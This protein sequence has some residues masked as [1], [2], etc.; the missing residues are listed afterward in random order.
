[1][2]KQAAKYNKAI[3]TGDLNF[4]IYDGQYGKFIK[5]SRYLDPLG[6]VYAPTVSPRNTNR[7]HSLI[8]PKHSIRVDYTLISKNLGNQLKKQKIIFDKPYQ[9]KNKLIH[10]SDHYGILTELT[11]PRA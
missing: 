9:A 8:W 5:K 7:E 3:I 2:L 1:M 6:T 4:T 11:P 10:V